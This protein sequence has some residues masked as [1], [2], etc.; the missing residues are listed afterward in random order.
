MRKQA[1]VPKSL[2][3]RGMDWRLYVNERPDPVKVA[4]IMES[5]GYHAAVERWGWL[6]AATVSHLAAE[7][8]KRMG[9]GQNSKL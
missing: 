3:H 2:K 8:R 4:R 7:G 1:P 6:S 5:H 9:V